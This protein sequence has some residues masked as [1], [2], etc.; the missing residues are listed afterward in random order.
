MAKVS[1]CHLGLPKGLPE[2]M[3]MRIGYR[4]H[5]DNITI[6]AKIGNYGGEE[7]EMIAGKGDRPVALVGCNTLFL[8]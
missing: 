5:A 7:F 4:T 2:H 1:C 8:W 3:I 6:F